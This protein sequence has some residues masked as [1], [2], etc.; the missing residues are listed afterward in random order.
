M[1]TYAP[2]ARIAFVVPEDVPTAQVFLM[3]LPDGTPVLLTGAGATIWIL[4]ADGEPDVA[5]AVGE[6]VG[7]PRDSVADDV[8][9]Y[10]VELVAQ[11]LLTTRE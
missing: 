6:A 4:A 3:S 9:K 5:A 8:E 11:G 1:T 7:M 2:P 10:L